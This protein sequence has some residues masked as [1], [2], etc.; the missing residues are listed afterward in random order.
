MAKPDTT[1]NQEVQGTAT[2][3]AKT[4]AGKEPDVQNQIGQT[5]EKIEGV[6][7]PEQIPSETETRNELNTLNKGIAVNIDALDENNFEKLAAIDHNKANQMLAKRALSVSRKLEK[8]EKQA[9]DANNTPVIEAISKSRQERAKGWAEAI[10]GAAKTIVTSIALGTAET[11]KALGSVIK[12]G[13]EGTAK[14]GL[15][16]G[17]KAVE[18]LWAAVF[19]SVRAIQDY[20]EERK[21]KLQQ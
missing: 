12:A 4:P 21:Q 10:G 9:I 3:A 16:V 18:L 11:V 6:I 13:I 7:N 5:Q 17:K 19:T 14:A 20:S 15:Y 8:A 1:K 2:E